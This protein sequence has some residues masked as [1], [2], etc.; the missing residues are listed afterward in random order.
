MKRKCT[1]PMRKA[2][3]VSHIGQNQYAFLQPFSL[4]SMKLSLLASTLRLHHRKDL[5]YLVVIV[6]DMGSTGEV[7]IVRHESPR[8]AAPFRHVENNLW[9]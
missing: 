1:T 8:W 9:L 5:F 3:L 4:F 6:K 7:T 2:L